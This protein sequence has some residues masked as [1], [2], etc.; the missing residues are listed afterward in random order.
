MIMLSPYD[1]KNKEFTKS[2]RGYSPEEVDE[3]IDFII[4]KYSELFRAYDALEKK[5]RIT[6]AQLDAMKEEESSIRAA[7]VN[8]QKASSRII[9]EANERA[10]IIM[11]SAKNG[12]DRI[13]SE[14]KSDITIENEKLTAIKKEAASF[15]A[16][17]FEAYHEHITQIEQIAPNES[18]VAQAD[19]AD[20][21]KYASLVMQKIKEDLSSR[22]EKNAEKTVSAEEVKPAKPKESIDPIEQLFSGENGDDAVASDTADSD[23]DYSPLEDSI[24]DEISEEDSYNKEEIKSEKNDDIFEI[25]RTPAAENSK[26]IIGSIKKI[27]KSIDSGNDTDF[28]NLI[29]DESLSEIDE[30]HVVY[31]G[32]KKN[33][34]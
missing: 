29:G 6:E 30:F 21:E 19:D 12:C 25:S 20:V 27:N 33:G 17:L 28:F 34:Q 1:L 13:I 7:L 22:A 23:K 5:L 10:D 3:H 32:K 9:D 8:A 24:F 15:K 16:A 31:D 26:G 2:L 11:Q 18:P 4:K 14:M